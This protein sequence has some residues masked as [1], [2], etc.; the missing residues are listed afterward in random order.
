MNP[1]NKPN[2]M[3]TGNENT[4]ITGKLQ[5]NPTIA[6]YTKACFVEFAVKNPETAEPSIIPNIP[7]NPID[8]NQ[9]III[10][11]MATTTPFKI[12]PNSKLL[13]ISSDIISLL[14]YYFGKKLII[15]LKIITIPIIDIWDN[16]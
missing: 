9:E 5:M 7:I 1:P 6:P 14:F 13:A 11:I 3:K 8:V 10:N 12:G 16:Y 4:V 2:M 15:F